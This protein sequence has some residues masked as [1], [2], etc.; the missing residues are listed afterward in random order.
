MR[1][2]AYKRFSEARAAHWLILVAADRVDSV[3]SHLRSFTTRRPDNPIAETGA[4]SELSHRGLSSRLGQ[5][6]AD[7]AHQPLDPI[8][9]AGPW[10]LGGALAYRGVRR[11]TRGRRPGRS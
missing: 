7:L 10:I 11:L 8:I 5:K 3:A 6:R 1:K 9:V 2:Y 4:R